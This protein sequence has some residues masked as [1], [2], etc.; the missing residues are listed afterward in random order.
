MAAEPELRKALKE[1]PSAEVRMRARRLRKEVRTP[2]PVAVLR[3]HSSE[4]E[5]VEFSPDGRLV[6]SG[7]TDGAVKL[8]DTATWK[9]TATLILPR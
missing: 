9:E 4:V 3:G 2:E 6:A 1:S 7:G 8:W 5:V